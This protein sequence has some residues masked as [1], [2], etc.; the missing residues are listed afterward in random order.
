[1]E[2]NEDGLDQEIKQK[3]ASSSSLDNDHPHFPKMP[4]FQ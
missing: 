4:E 1:M 3:V 2:A